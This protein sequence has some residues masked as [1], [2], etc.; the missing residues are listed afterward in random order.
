MSNTQDYSSLKW[1]KGEL[2]E[3]VRLAR[4]DLEEH[5]EGG[6][7]AALMESCA[8]RLHQIQ[9][10]LQMVQIYGAAMLAEEMELVARAIARDEIPK[11]VEAAEALLQGLIKLPD[12]LEQLLEG[13]RDHPVILTPLLNDLR[14]SREQSLY[15]E[16]ALFA[17]ELDQWLQAG[18]VAETPNRRLRKIARGLR[19][20]FHKG[21]LDWYLD[22]DIAGGLGAIREVLLELEDSA[23]TEQVKRLFRIARAASTVPLED[24]NVPNIAM[25]QLLGR[26]D[27]E[28][29]RIISE[30]E[31]AVA[32]RPPV[33]LQKNLLYYVTSSH[34]QNE[35]TQF[36]RQEFDLDR[37]L[38]TYSE[39][40]SG[41]QGLQGPNLELLQSLRTAIGT[42]LDS[43]KDA[44]DLFIRTKS[45]DTEQL[46]PLEHSMSVIADTLGMVGQGALRQRIKRQADKIKEIVASSVAPDENDLLA[47]AQDII[48]VESSL[49]NLAASRRAQAEIPAEEESVGV[50]T[51]LPAGEFERLVDSVMREA[52]IDMAQIKDAIITFIGAPEKVDVLHDVPTRFRSIAGAFEMLKLFDVSGLLRAIAGYVAN[53]I[54]AK[55]AVPETARLNAF[56]D[57]VTSVEYFMEAVTEGRGVHDEILEVAREAL[58]RLGTEEEPEEA[59]APT[60]SVAGEAPTPA[61][62]APKPPPPAPVPEPE[63]IASAD[64]PALEEISPE[65]LDIF[66]E[67]AREELEVI[68]E[69]MPRWLANHDEQDALIT[70]RRSFHTLK[71]SG[72]LVGAKTIG[73]FAWS[74]ENLLNRVIDETLQV[75]DPIAELLQETLNV[76][77][78]LIECQANGTAPQTDVQAM[79]DRAFELVNQSRAPKE[80]AVEA[81]AEK[82]V[83]PEEHEPLSLSGLEVEEIKLEE[84]A[85]AEPQPEP[86][87]EAEL[88]SEP[89]PE[90]AAPETGKAPISLDPVLLEIFL[91]E[92]RTHLDTINEFL[93][94]YREGGGR[95]H[96]DNSLSRAYHTLHG[97]AHMAEVVPIAQLS[98]AVEAYLNDMLEHNRPADD[99]VADLLER[100][101][102]QI[103]SV[104]VAINVPDARLPDWEAL[105]LEVRAKHKTLRGDLGIETTVVSPIED[106]DEG[107]VEETAEAPAEEPFE[108]ELEEIPAAPV[109][110]SLEIEI[111]ELPEE[112]FVEAPT[113]PQAPSV[114]PPGKAPKPSTPSATETISMEQELL[115]I[116]LGEAEELMDAIDH[117]LRQWGAAPS[118]LEAVAELQRTLHTLKGGARLAGIL[119]IGDLSHAFESLLEGVDHRTVP[120]SRGMYLYA[121]SVA[122]HLTSQIEEARASGSATPAED[123]IEEMGQVLAGELE[124]DPATGM[125]RAPSKAEEVTA[126]EIEEK[127]AVE[128]GEGI[129]VGAELEEREEPQAPKEAAPEPEAKLEPEEPESEAEAE[130]EIEAIEE[131]PESEPEPEITEFEPPEE[132]RAE[133]EP[134]P[135]PEAKPEAPDASQV[136]P[137][138]TVEQRQ[139]PGV[140]APE[141]TS[142]EELEPTRLVRRGGREQLRINPEVMDKLVNNSGEVSIFRSR[143]EQQ[144]SALGFN[145]K[146]LEQTVTRLRNQLRQLDIETEAQIL[147]RYERDQEEGKETD[148]DFD[149]LELD[150][151]STIQQL[152]RSLLETVGD[153]VSINE[154]LEEEQRET[155]TILLQQARVATDLQDGLLRTRMV[156]FSQLEPRL[157][158]LMRQ[159]C[160]QLN[161]QAVM[162]MHGT[163]MELDR[164]ILDRITAPLEHLVRNAVSHGIESPE[165]RRELGKDETGRIVF[166][167]TREGN[168]VQIKISDDGAGLDLEAIR[169]QAL[170]LG[171]LVEGAQ[172]SD[173]ELMQFILEQGF[174]TA[175]EVSQ[176]SGRGVGLDVVVSEVKQM[177]GSLEID[178]APG[179]GT[180]FAIQLPLTLAITTGLLLQLGDEV[181]AVPHNAIEGVVRVSRD[182]LQACYE[183]RQ[184]GYVY[185]A[186]TYPIRYLGSILGTAQFTMPE[187]GKWF[188]LM[189]VRVGEH[190]VALQ[191]DEF[192]GHRQIVVKSVGP[193]LST[194]RWF[195]G[196]TILADGR[197]ALILDVNALARMDAARTAEAAVVELA[198]Y[199]EEIAEVEPGVGAKVMVVDDSITVRKVTGRLLERHGMEVMTANDGVD[200]VA[201]LQEYHPDVMLLDI[202][203]P[204]MDGFELARHMKNSEELRDI[205]I[206]II[207]SRTGEKHRNVALELGVKRYLGKPYQE[208]ELLETIHDVLAE[209]AAE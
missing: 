180:S 161:K 193:Q 105:A 90:E 28:I 154:L 207:T 59:A 108:I 204:R 136:L 84:P 187:Q 134:E 202:E 199:P 150:R 140:P 82:P 31:L 128:P 49:E 71:G 96:L 147:F 52:R 88:V 156:S 198:E 163:E 205:P 131:E 189:L 77:P 144:N 47:I 87:L 46:L 5:I 24:P 208:T 33:D 93:E 185:G 175:D 190:R 38:I 95:R 153:L 157:Q 129:F 55:Q 83:E 22:R 26:V 60:E 182:Q 30:G 164:S 104:L 70:F 54:L 10:T 100:S 66:M 4:Q 53:E 20:K 132:L 11:K 184:E 113:P 196:G 158:R 195:T 203:M 17:P 133:E 174:S 145:L 115:E 117:A 130:V 127:P 23:G 19:H 36:L 152:S 167:L 89:E 16:A 171:L 107:I 101:V 67:E 8:T 170:N 142:R 122:D 86:E 141:A 116:F 2:D 58:L 74:I 178:S 125:V 25:K 103:E 114:T 18:E 78:E 29:K 123:L 44:L 183:E 110:E 109:D 7:D 139:P 194:I 168:N 32:E 191:V 124:V 102:Q 106:E 6:G 200:A 81:S 27:R 188:P 57:A 76:L 65:I 176:I 162:E 37:E 21:L 72:R 97:S 146:E 56:A 14:A 172:I 149:P 41:R 98:S 192:L 169:A 94:Q 79:M 137:F 206:I 51:E 179:K 12:Y 61:A 92:S 112:P 159:T 148:E 118:D 68:R 13:G 155:D 73:E 48:Y 69:Y 126:E 166:E 63:H 111:A 91:A 120:N 197:V 75:S 45:S 177:S 1:I 143:L 181:Y 119:A 62:A 165:R 160:R 39:I 40:E 50:E 64:K 135:E 9:G 138:P 85:E 35:L 3:A 99:E 15:S 151:F 43:I 186:H 80:E 173:N 209:K 42:D 121:Q 34:A 201:K